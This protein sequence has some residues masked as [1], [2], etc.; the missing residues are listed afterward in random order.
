[1]AINNYDHRRSI[2][3]P[4]DVRDR[5]FRTL[6]KY[7]VRS[8]NYTRYDEPFYSRNYDNISSYYRPT[9]HCTFEIIL[10]E[11]GLKDMVDDLDRIEH[12]EWL[13]KNNP[14]LQ[15]AWEHYQTVLGLVK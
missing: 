15:K 2:S 4:V 8:A 14:S 7:R 12:E 9:D 11:Q 1:M 13:R 3:Q 6:Q 5:Y 10:D